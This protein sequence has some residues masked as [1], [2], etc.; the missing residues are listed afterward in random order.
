MTLMP[1]TTLAEPRNIAIRIFRAQ[2]P[3]L[4]F[5]RQAVVEVHNRN[6]TDDATLIEFLS[7]RSRYLLLAV[8]QDRVL[9]SLHGQALR[10]PHR[11]EPQFLLYE[12]DVRPEYG[13]QGVGKA[14]V[15]SFIEEAEA[16]GAFE[17]WVL[18]DESNPAALAMYTSCGLRR[19]GREQIML[20]RMFEGRD[21]LLPLQ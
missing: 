19:E 2:P 10:H 1:A 11:C 4:E 13:N 21:G 20:N 5:A 17:A 18:T 14:L 12:I 8:Q 16:A 6:L 9:G 7:D 3:D 15:Q